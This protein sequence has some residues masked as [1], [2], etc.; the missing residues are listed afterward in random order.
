MPITITELDASLA[1]FGANLVIA[2][3]PISKALVDIVEA[4]RLMAVQLGAKLENVNKSIGNNKSAVPGGTPTPQTGWELVLRRLQEAIDKKSTV[5]GKIFAGVDSLVGSLGKYLGKPGGITREVGKKLISPTGPLG[6][7][8]IQ[9]F[10]AA[11][12]FFEKFAGALNPGLLDLFNQALENLYATIGVAVVPVFQVLIRSLEQIGGILLP[13][14]KALAP[15]V[16]KIANV[17]A[18]R[19]LTLLVLLISLFDLFAPVLNGLFKIWIAAMDAV[20]KGFLILFVWLYRTFGANGLADD[21]IKRLKDRNIARGEIAR[22]PASITTLDS[23]VKD[24]ATSSL[25]AAA[26]GARDE[27]TLDDIVNVLEKIE[28]SSTLKDLAAAVQDLV[29]WLNESRTA[30]ANNFI[31]D[32]VGHSIDKGTSFIQKGIE[33]SPFGQVVSGVRWLGRGGKSAE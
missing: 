9:G 10:L 3:E 16:Q 22:G 18:D 2:F 21:I 31:N 15:V 25:N 7:F 24:L 11:V 19:L 1:K 27:S 20:T 30:G 23:I 32:P 17:L 29:K 13:V 8:S 28:G 5:P 12:S 14:M 33:W 26:G 4:I 6:G